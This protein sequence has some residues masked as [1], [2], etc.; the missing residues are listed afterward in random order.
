MIKIS[1]SIPESV[2]REEDM[3]VVT[4]IFSTPKSTKEKEEERRV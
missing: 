2:I 1:T 3:R 4:L